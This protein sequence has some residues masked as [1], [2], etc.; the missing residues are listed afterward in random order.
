M[1]L[2]LLHQKAMA[3][4]RISLLTMLNTPVQQQ[5]ITALK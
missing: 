3:I 4:F 1:E 2:E 5:F